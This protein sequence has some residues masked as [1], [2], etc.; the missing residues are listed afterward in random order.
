MGLKAVDVSVVGGLWSSIEIQSVALEILGRV[1]ACS[2]I[3]FRAAQC[4][5]AGLFMYLQIPIKIRL[6]SH[7]LRLLT[8]V[9]SIAF[10]L[11]VRVVAEPVGT[12]TPI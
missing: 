9:I 10:L 11:G 8:F 7:L 3:L 6:L 12:I 1:E 2:L 4:L 5:A